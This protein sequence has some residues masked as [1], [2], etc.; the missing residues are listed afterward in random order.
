MEPATTATPTPTN[1]TTG[2]KAKLL[3]NFAEITM[4]KVVYLVSL[5]AFSLQKYTIFR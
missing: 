2:S 1:K 3:G 5:I 4:A